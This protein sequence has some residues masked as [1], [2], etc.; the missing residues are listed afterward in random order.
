LESAPA[1]FEA[2]ARTIEQ[3]PEDAH[4]ISNALKPLTRSRREALSPA[5]ALIEQLHPWVAFGIMPLFALANAGVLVRGM[6]VG[7]SSG[8]VALGVSIGLVLGKPVGIMLVTG[9]AL[10]LR[11]V[12]LPAGIGLAHLL[13]LGSVAGIGFTMALF[14]AQLAFVDGQL[15]AAAKLGVLTASAAAGGLGLALG[16]ILLSAPEANNSIALSADEA[17]RSTER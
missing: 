3:G 15:L 7:G 8:L 14:I 1:H 5:E 4:A 13:V 11:L 9:I 2:L 10:K 16:R 6:S 17:E 12:R